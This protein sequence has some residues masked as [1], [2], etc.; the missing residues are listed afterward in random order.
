LEPQWR[1]LRYVFGDRLQFR[2]H[3]GGLLPRWDRFQDAVHVVSQAGQ[4]APLWIQIAEMTGAPL[5]SRLWTEDPPASSFPASLAFK[6]AERQGAWAAEAYLRRL[7]EAAM[8]QR[9]NIARPEVLLAIA[10]EA[11]ADL[12]ADLPLDVERFGQDFGAAETREAFRSDLQQARYHGIKRFPSLLLRCAGGRP[13][14]CVGYRSFDSLLGAL[15]AVAPGLEP[16]RTV[17]LTAYTAFWGRLTQAELTEALQ[18]DGR[19]TACAMDDAVA[20]GEVAR[21]SIVG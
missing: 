11:A 7:R 13:V 5:D 15:H 2:Y 18:V 3:M 9:R 16:Q 6:A 17:S 19:A 14:V 12:P 20:R 21:S 1:R 10:V 4:M 8:L